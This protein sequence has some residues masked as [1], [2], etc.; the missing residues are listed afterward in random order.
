MHLD[1]QTLIDFI[2][3]LGFFHVGFARARYLEEEADRLENWLNQSY[4]GE[5]NY[6]ERYFDFRLDPQKLMPGCK[7]IIVLAMNYFQDQ[8]QQMKIKAKFPCMP[9]ARTIIRLLDQKQRRSFS[10]CGINM[11]T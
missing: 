5:M 9:W 8:E 11:A 10:G 4:Q 2:N 3:S 1:K 6:L 7:T